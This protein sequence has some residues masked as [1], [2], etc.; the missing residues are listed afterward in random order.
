MA[1]GGPLLGLAVAAIGSFFHYVAAGPDE[2]NR[3][4]E[5]VAAD[6]AHAGQ[7]QAGQEGE[8]TH[9]DA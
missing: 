5:T 7:D 4:D 2:V 6:M 9:R 3:A 1:V 8:G